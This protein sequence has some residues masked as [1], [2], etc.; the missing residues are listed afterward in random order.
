MFTA[1]VIIPGIFVAGY[2]LRV[3]RNT[4]R[5]DSEMPEFNEWLSMFIDGLKVI[6]VTIMYYLVPAI[7]LILGVG[8]F[9]LVL[10]AY[11]VADLSLINWPWLITGVL[12]FIPFIMFYMIAIANMAYHNSLAA[13]FSMG[14]IWQRI[15]AIG[16]GRF[17]VWWLATM[18]VSAIFASA[19]QFIEMISS[20]V[21]FFMVPLLID[22]FIALFQARSMGLIYREEL[23][24]ENNSNE[25]VI[26]DKSVQKD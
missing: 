13:A 5:G 15:R 2:T 4:I 21:G 22:S 6:A 11:D 24:T 9:Y 18:I 25:P 20:I 10:Y 26:G 16:Y 12:L 14:K 1:Y 17:I 8:Q 23:N 3:T 19:G 7:I